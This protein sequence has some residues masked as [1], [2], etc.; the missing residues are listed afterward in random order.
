MRRKTNHA[1]PGLILRGDIWHIEK[2]VKIGGQR[3]RLRESTG[4]GTLAEA[5]D[6]LDARVYA[7]RE[8]LLNGPAAPVHAFREAAAEYIADLEMR[9][10]DSRRAL[11]DLKML[12]PMV[13]H[14]PVGHVHQGALRDWIAAQQGVRSS[15]TVDRA[16]RTVVTVLTFA[17]RVLRDGDQPWLATVPKLTS[18]DWGSRQPVRITW[19]QQDRLVASLP[20]HLV[21]P[22]LFAVATGARQEEVVSLRWDQHRPQH[23]LPAWSC[24]WIPPEIRKASSKRKASEQ[25]GRYVVCNTMARSVIVG[26]VGRH[27]TVVFPSP[28]PAKDGDGRLYR[29]NNHGWRE[30]C[31]AAGITMRVHDLRHTWGERAADAGIPLEV[32]RSL[33]GHEHRDITLHYSAP[34]LARLLEEAERIVRPVPSLEAVPGKLFALR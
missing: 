1:P 20:G 23:G 22:V 33:L 21:A 13:G 7:V 16:L 10:K 6:I 4:T 34:G 29:I 12:D 14:L 24:W 9:G 18:P 25:Q 2:I 31:K 15:G 11:Q 30:A 28:R 3:T 17:A 27:E 26:Q 19:E 5:I 32:R 8:S